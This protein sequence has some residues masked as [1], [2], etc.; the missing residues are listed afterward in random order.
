MKKFTLMLSA[1][2]LGIAS[3]ALAGEYHPR[4]GDIVFGLVYF[5]GFGEVSA[6]RVCRDAS[7]GVLRTEIPAATQQVCVET[8]VDHDVMPPHVDCVRYET[9]STPARSLSAGLRVSKEV[10]KEVRYDF[11]NS[12]NGHPVCVRTAVEIVDQPLS[13][14]VQSFDNPIHQAPTS[15]TYPVRSCR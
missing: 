12:A 10:C 14:S 11:E 13:F 5:P 3:V 2:F 9:V 4:Q 7:A 8:A 15:A 1:L 6:D